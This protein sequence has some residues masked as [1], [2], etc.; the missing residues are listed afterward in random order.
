MIKL[1]PDDNNHPSLAKTQ[2]RPKHL[3]N[4]F[5]QPSSGGLLLSCILPRWMTTNA[6]LLAIGA[7]V[8]IISTIVLVHI[9]AAAELATAKRRLKSLN[10]QSQIS[11]AYN[12]PSRRKTTARGHDRRRTVS[13]E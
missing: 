11:Q 7:L 3:P 4:S 12:Y 5:S 1:T 8:G 10:E 13:D 2:S 6:W 9:R